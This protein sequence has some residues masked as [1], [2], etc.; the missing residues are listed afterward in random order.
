MTRDEYEARRRRLDEELRAALELLKA[1]HQAQLQALD[2]LW[3]TSTD[4]GATPP[5]PAA[6]PAPERSRPRRRGPGELLQEVLAVLPGLPEV[7]TKDDVGKVLSDPPDRASLFRVLREL[8]E[9]G[10][11][12]VERYGSGRVPT[13]YVREPSASPA[14]GPRN[15]TDVP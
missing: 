15:A 2:L 5:G 9:S 10:R 12:R 4:G 13:V 8:E 14:A 11:L 3:K 7:F 6:L 1:G